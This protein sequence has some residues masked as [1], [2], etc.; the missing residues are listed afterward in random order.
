MGIFRFLC[1]YPDHL[2]EYISWFDTNGLSEI[3]LSPSLLLF[4]KMFLVCPISDWHM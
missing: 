1:R 2:T 3:G 4:A